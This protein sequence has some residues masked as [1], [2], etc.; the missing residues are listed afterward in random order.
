MSGREYE[1]LICCELMAGCDLRNCNL[2]PK[3]FGWV[4]WGEGELKLVIGSVIDCVRKRR[5]ELVVDTMMG[6]KTSCVWAL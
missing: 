1:G 3:L 5:T 6:A 2:V 4:F